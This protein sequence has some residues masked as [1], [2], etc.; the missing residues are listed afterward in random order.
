MQGDFT[1]NL[2]FSL[3]P[4]GTYDVTGKLVP[5][6]EPMWDPPTSEPKPPEPPKTSEPPATSS[7]PTSKP[8]YSSEIVE[9]KT[10]EPPAPKPSA[11]PTSQPPTSK[12]SS[13]VITGEVP[14]FDVVSNSLA[15]P[16]YQAEEGEM[17]GWEYPS[18]IYARSALRVYGTVK[19]DNGVYDLYEKQGRNPKRLLKAGVLVQ[20]VYKDGLILKAFAV[21][22][23]NGKLSLISGVSTDHQNWMWQTEQYRNYLPK[24][25]LGD[26]LHAQDG[27]LWIK[28][29]E[30]IKNSQGVYTDYRRYWF[31]NGEPLQIDLP[32]PKTGRRYDIYA[33]SVFKPSVKDWDCRTTYVALLGL[34]HITNTEQTW[35][36]MGTIDLVWATSDD[37]V[38]WD[39]PF[40]D[41]PAVD[42]GSMVGMVVPGAFLPYGKDLQVYCGAARYTH[43]TYD[44]AKDKTVGTGVITMPQSKFEKAFA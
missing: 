10:S 2:N 35:N 9:P 12:P 34:F 23:A 33:M 17:R 26:V 44:F 11:P 39:L 6:E 4:D 21:Q 7:P 16:R 27:K 43:N 15:Y 28:G 18:A 1:A 20:S 3:N 38:H 32:K 37:G 19:G 36:H 13:P 14:M 30:F 8:K 29:D 41:K 42:R 22:K 24:Y 25:N 31:C 40:G 5:E